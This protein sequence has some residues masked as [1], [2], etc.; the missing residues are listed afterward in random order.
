MLC[1]TPALGGVSAFGQARVAVQQDTAIGRPIERVVGQ[2]TILRDEWGTPHVYAAREE[3]GYYGWGY[4]MAEDRLESVLRRYLAVQ[5]RLAATFG[6]NERALWHGALAFPGSM[7]E[8]DFLHARWRHWEEGKAG[9]TR[10]APQLQRNY[11]QFVAG[12]ERYMQDHPQAVPSW[13]P[14]GLDPALPVAFTR[15][16]FF[17]WALGAQGVRDCQAGGVEIAADV[18][19]DARPRAERIRRCSGGI[20]RVE[21]VGADAVAHVVQRVGTSLRF[22]RPMG[23]AG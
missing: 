22:A 19:R 4:A 18:Q 9:Y 1:A 12:I 5:G 21:C 10:L 13:A 6:A 14:A 17:S 3:D 23:R 11:Q 2:V 16:W 7:L 20:A 8:S 15:A